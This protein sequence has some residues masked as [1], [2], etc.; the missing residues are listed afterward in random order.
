MSFDFVL[1]LFKRSV[2]RIRIQGLI[3]SNKHASREVFSL[4]KKFICKEKYGTVTKVKL[5]TKIKNLSQL[6]F[7]TLV[8]ASYCYCGDTKIL[9]SFKTLVSCLR[10]ERHGTSKV[11]E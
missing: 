4:H 11:S 8:L 7:G 3:G 2:K 9:T 1:T 5:V 6:Y 10:K